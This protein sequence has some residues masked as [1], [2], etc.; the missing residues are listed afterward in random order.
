MPIEKNEALSLNLAAWS[1]LL[2][3]NVDFFRGGDG[4]RFVGVRLG[5]SVATAQPQDA[6]HGDHD[7]QPHEKCRGQLHQ[8]WYSKWWKS[9]VLKRAP[10]TQPALSMAKTKA[11]LKSA[12]PTPLS[13]LDQAS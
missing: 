13:A 3:S 8:V 1:E 4:R 9:G 5:S 7:E 6:A 10:Q 12:K 11:G 2:V